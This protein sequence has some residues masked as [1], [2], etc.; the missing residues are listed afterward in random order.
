MHQ[1]KSFHNYTV[2]QAALLVL[3]LCLLRKL[4]LE[5]F[6]VAHNKESSQLATLSLLPMYLQMLL[7]SVYH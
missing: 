6:F 3:P 4:L 5:L 7:F 1:S 2:E